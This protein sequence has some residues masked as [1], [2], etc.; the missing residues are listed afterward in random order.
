MERIENLS[1]EEY[2]RGEKYSGHV[3]STQL[4]QLL[5]SPKAFKYYIEH[6]SDST[7]E[8]EFGSLFHTAMELFAR[9]GSID[10]FYDYVSVF[11]PPVNER[12]GNPC[13][14]TTN[15]YQE[16]YQAFLAENDGKIITTEETVRKIDDMVG[17]LV[18]PAIGGETA[19]QVLKLLKWCKETEVSYFYETSDGIKLKIRPDMLTGNKLV[20]WKTCSLDSLDEDRIARQIIKYRYDVSISMYQYVLHEF[21]GKWYKPYLVFVTKQEP[22][23]AVVVD[24]SDWCYSYDADDDIVSSGVGALEFSRLL[25]IYKDCVQSGEYNGAASATNGEILRPKVPA[26]FGNKLIEI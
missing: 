5:K 10:A 16:A 21:T 6:P 24:I 2:H 4:K 1:N 7:K 11:E 22:Y 12:T 3:S 25:K 19:N 17:M 8:M 9:Y 15:A 18:N 14:S 26:W 13:G 20:D 23:D